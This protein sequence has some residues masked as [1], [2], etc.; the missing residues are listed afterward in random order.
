MVNPWYTRLTEARKFLAALT[1]AAAAAI[2]AGVL[3]GAAERWTSVILAIVT[4]FVVFLIKN[5]PATLE[6]ATPASR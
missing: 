4:A 2:S 1:G 3:S 6:A 5:E